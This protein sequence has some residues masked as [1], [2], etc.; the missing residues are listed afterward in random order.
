LSRRCR[1]TTFFPSHERFVAPITEALNLE[2]YPLTYVPDL[3]WMLPLFLLVA[4]LYGSVGHGGA[5]GYLALMALLSFAPDTLRPTALTLNVA[6]SGLAAVLFFRAGHFRWPLF[7][8]FALVSIPCAW[9]GG[10]LELPPLAFKLLLGLTLAFAAVRL[11]LPDRPSPRGKGDS[12]HLAP[13]RH[14]P[15]AASL[16]LGAL[17]GLLSG[18]VGVGGGIFLTP[19]LVLARWADPRLAAAVSAPFILVNSLAGLAGQTRVF[20]RLPQGW[21]LLAAVVV[22]GG[23]IG[24]LWGSR[25]ATMARLRPAL[26]VVLAIASLKLLLA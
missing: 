13:P 9:L 17:L 12:G 2:S 1:K 8:P 6:V 7:W 11:L 5:S 21:P 14:P 24:A 19:L 20:E 3:V 23:F 15:L 18:L 26:A 16:P 22:A 4:A 25:H 10:R